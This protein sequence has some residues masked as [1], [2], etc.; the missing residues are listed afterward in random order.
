VG[1]EARQV[2]VSWDVLARFRR[3]CILELSPEDGGPPRYGVLRGISELEALIEERDGAPRWVPREVFRRIW[4]GSVWILTPGPR[5]GEGL[6]PGSRGEAVRWLQEAL[7][8]LGH[9]DGGIPGLFDEDT[10]R[11]VMAFQ[12]DTGLPVDGRVGAQT[13]G[14]ILQLLGDE[15]QR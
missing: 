9:L 2:T 12:R 10:R 1:L 13:A 15:A 5:R 3:A 14:M 11:G 4:F 8:R 7:E 6:I